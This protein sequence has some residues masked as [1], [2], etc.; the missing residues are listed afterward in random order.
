V[1]TD[2]P[3]FESVFAQALEMGVSRMDFKASADDSPG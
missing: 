2:V 1:S 3:A